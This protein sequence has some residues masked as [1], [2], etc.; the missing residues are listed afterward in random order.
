MKECAT[1]QIERRKILIESNNLL[2]SLNFSYPHFLFR[3][4]VYNGYYVVLVILLFI[5]IQ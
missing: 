2:L 1:V 4:Y 5:I 3:Y